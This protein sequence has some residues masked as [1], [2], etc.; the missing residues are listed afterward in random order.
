M[1]SKGSANRSEFLSCQVAF[2][3]S[4]HT[5]CPLHTFCVTFTLFISGTTFFAAADGMLMKCCALCSLFFLTVLNICS[6]LKCLN[7]CLYFGLHMLV[8]VCVCGLC[9]CMRLDKTLCLC[10]FST[11]IVLQST[12]TSTRSSISSSVSTSTYP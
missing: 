11:V 1:H 3:L 4:C 8:C 7:A 5:P 2:G 6:H 12:G 9:V 10:H